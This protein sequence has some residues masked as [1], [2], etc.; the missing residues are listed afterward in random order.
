MDTF[1]ERI[2]S[3]QT[4]LKVRTSPMPGGG[5]VTTY[6]DIAE[7]VHAEQALARANENLEKRIRERTEEL[8]HVNDEPVR[9]KKEA[10]EAN[11]GK[12]RFLAAAGHDILKPLNA[13]RLYPSTLMERFEAGRDYD[14]VHNVERS[15]D[16][17][18]EIIGTVLDISRLDTGRMQPE[19]SSF[20]L[21]SILSSS[22]R[23]HA[24]RSWI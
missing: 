22:S 20:R 9:A 10:N 2:A 18:E 12:T 16:S 4:V 14:L 23:W 24:K 17:V 5:I 3:T 11:L 1:Q 15:L 8:T 19:I 7:R 13:G 6:T 21:D